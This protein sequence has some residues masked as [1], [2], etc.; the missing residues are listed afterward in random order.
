[1][2]L[3]SFITM[4]FHENPR[5]FILEYYSEKK[6]QIDLKCEEAILES[7]DSKDIEVLCKLRMNLIE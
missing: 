6:N 4:D 5:L 7:K 2:S 1:M 3:E